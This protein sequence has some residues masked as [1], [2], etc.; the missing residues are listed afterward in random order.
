MKP[1][2]ASQNDGSLE[3]FLGEWVVD[4]P[5]PP[6]FQEKVWKQVQRAETPLQATFWNALR[7]WLE[8]ALP[9]PQLAFSYAA[10][11]LAVGLAAGAWAAQTHNA[12]MEASLGSRYLQ[13]ID[14]YQ[15]GSPT[16]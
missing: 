1:N 12:R 9:R 11:L 13:S 7:R 14:P 16:R 5:L 10:L 6:R 2:Q 3:R 15:S 8:T 4:A